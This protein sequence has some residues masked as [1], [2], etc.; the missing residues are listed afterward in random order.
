MTVRRRIPATTRTFMGCAAD[1][2]LGV[3]VAVAEGGP[4]AA[5]VRVAITRTV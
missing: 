5:W 4:S 1:V 3:P 2:A